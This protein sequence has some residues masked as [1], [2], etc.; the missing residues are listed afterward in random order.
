MPTDPVLNALGRTYAQ[1][2]EEGY[3]P[4]EAWARLVAHYPYAATLGP[5]TVRYYYE[6]GLRTTERL[7]REAALGRNPALWQGRATPIPHELGVTVYLTAT[8]ARP[9]REDRVENLRLHLHWS[10][11]L[12]AVQAAV[13]HRAQQITDAG[14]EAY[15]KGWV[16]RGSTE[17]T[18]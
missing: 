17:F 7:N 6:T 11:R 16:L 10:D 12:E 18:D 2:R 14:S 13:E 5:Q 8:F 3:G 1:L 9:G 15:P 4:A